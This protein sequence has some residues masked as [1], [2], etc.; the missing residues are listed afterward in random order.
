MKAAEAALNASRSK[1]QRYQPIDTEGAIAKE[2]FEEAK[3][4]VEQHQQEVTAAKARLQSAKAALNPSL[5]EV[6]IARQ[7][8]EQ[9]RNRTKSTNTNFCLSPSRLWHSNRKGHLSCSRYD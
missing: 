8:I 1:L 5:A 2:Q 4:A 3:L 7:R 6:A 9:D